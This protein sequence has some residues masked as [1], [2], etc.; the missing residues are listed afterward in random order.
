MSEKMTGQE[1][2]QRLQKDSE[3]YANDREGVEG[4]SRIDEVSMAWRDGYRAAIG[5]LIPQP[6]LIEL[7]CE[8]DREKS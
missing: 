8:R 1:C 2:W 4:M 6:R 7:R 3:D 5:D